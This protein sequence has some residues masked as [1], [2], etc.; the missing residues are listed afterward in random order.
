[1]RIWSDER[2]SSFYQENSTRFSNLT[3]FSLKKVAYTYT[4]GFLTGVRRL[5]PGVREA[6]LKF[7]TVVRFVERSIYVE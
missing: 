7:K 5:I 3:L 4:R 6:L 1:M 2:C